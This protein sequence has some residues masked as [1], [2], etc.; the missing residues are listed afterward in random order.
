MQ[1]SAATTKRLLWFCVDT[2]T[3]LYLEFEDAFIECQCTITNVWAIMEFL[4]YC[5]DTV[6]FGDT[7]YLK[8]NGLESE[9]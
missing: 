1:F 6:I 5:H 7:T 9:N 8:I 3:F 2:N 4:G